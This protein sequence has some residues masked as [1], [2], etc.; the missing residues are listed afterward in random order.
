MTEFPD[1][2]SHTERGNSW[3]KEAHWVRR[4]GMGMGGTLHPTPPNPQPQVKV[5]SSCK[6]R[7]EEV[8]RVDSTMAYSVSPA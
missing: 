8:G 4:R 2:A 3:E 5:A 7:G 6:A 1:T